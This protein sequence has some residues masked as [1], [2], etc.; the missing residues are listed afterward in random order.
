MRNRGIYAKQSGKA[1]QVVIW[2][3]IWRRWG[4][5]SGGQLQ[6]EQTRQ[7]GTAGVNTPGQ[8]HPWGVWGTAR[9]LWLEQ[10]EEENRGKGW[11]QEY[12]RPQEG[13]WASALMVVIWGLGTEE[14]R[15]LTYALKQLRLLGVER[16]KRQWEECCDDQTRDDGGWDQ[17]QQWRGW[18][19]VGFGIKVEGR[20]DMIVW[21]TPPWSRPCFPPPSAAAP[22]HHHRNRGDSCQEFFFFREWKK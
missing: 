1:V 7:K 6:E 11:G 20:G 17:G 22:T 12:W 15:D 5:E 18:K 9:R 3:E 13:L 2:A 4:W 10:S 16:T 21:W 8:D 14:W 19:L